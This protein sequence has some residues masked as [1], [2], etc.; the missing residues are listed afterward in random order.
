MYFQL[1]G[2]KLATVEYGIGE[3]TGI[4]KVFT[5]AEDYEIVTDA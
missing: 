4:A 1:S 3:C 5:G 2:G